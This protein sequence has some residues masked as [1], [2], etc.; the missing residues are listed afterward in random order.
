MG[1]ALQ[2]GS[3]IRFRPEGQP[4]C[5]TWRL[6]LPLCVRSEDATTP[7]GQPVTLSAVSHETSNPIAYFLDCIRNNKPV[8][9]PLSSKLNVQVMEI[10]DAARE[11]V[12]TGRAVE[13]R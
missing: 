8:E 3:G 7:E 11:S 2:H 12:R 13:V 5:K 10:L 9:D 6:I 4:A 1:L